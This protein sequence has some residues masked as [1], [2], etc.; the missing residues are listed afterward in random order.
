MS[1]VEGEEEKGGRGRGEEEEKE[2]RRRMRNSSHT[3]VVGFPDTMLPGDAYCQAIETLDLDK[4]QGGL[5][6]YSLPR[7]RARC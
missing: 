3:P 5:C 1:V 4:L 2:K 6:T 7:N